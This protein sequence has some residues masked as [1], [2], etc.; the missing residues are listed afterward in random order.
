[1]VQRD[2][3]RRIRA[4]HQLQVAGVPLVARVLVQDVVLCAPHEG[5]VRDGP[6]LREHLRIRDGRLVVDRV[7][8][9]ERVALDDLQLVAV[10]DAVA[11]GEGMGRLVL[12]RRAVP[13]HP[14]VLGEV[15]DLDHQ[16]VAFPA[17]ARVAHPEPDVRCYRRAPVDR[18]VAE[19]VVPLVEQDHRVG[20][21]QELV[22]VVAHRQ[23]AARH[24]GRQALDARIEVL[25]L[26]PLRHD[27]FA[28]L[29][30]PL[31][32]RDLAVRRIHDHRLLLAHDV[33]RVG[34]AGEE[35][36][37]RAELPLRLRAHPRLAAGRVLHRRGGAGHPVAAQ[38]GVAPLRARRRER[39]VL[40][41]GNGRR[42]HGQHEARQEQAD[43]GGDGS[44]QHAAAL[45]RRP[46]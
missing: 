24:G 20:R 38:I 42:E 11:R 10:E 41:G 34:M 27:L 39:R 22:R 26:V 21:L 13:H 4:G 12:R 15:G 2:A 31:L 7:G 30:G 17:P 19:Q 29:G 25:Q 8:V 45:L 5:V 37:A 43:G 35:P 46:H 18:D 28:T 44:V 32:Q 6:G 1:M 40:A 33:G 9:N 23:V 16:R 14:G 3:R 36:E